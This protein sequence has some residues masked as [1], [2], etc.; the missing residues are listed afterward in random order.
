M[1][2]ALAFLMLFPSLL[3]GQPVG[4]SA[5][6]IMSKNWTAKQCRTLIRALDL[7]EEPA[8]AILWRS[9]GTA[10]RCLESIKRKAAASPKNWYIEIHLSNE[11]ARRSGRASEWDLL[12]ALT[13]VEYSQSLESPNGET[14]GAV[15]S[16]V[17]KIGEVVTDLPNTRWGLTL[18]LESNLSLK[19]AKKLRD[20][21]RQWW[22]YEIVYSPLTGH[23]W[24]FGGRISGTTYELHGYSELAATGRNNCIRN[25]DGTGIAHNGPRSPRWRYF[26]MQQVAEWGRIG[27]EN[28]CILLFWQDRWQGVDT[29]NFIP[30]RDRS[31]T[32][33][34]RDFNLVK[35]LMRAI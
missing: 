35:K 11:A 32:F 3:W 27:R 6:Q 15:S 12:P 20:L 24:A 17:R 26:T 29:E 30:H 34:R 5:Y 31:F 28:S 14:L 2:R 8:V 10:T 33:D 1:G 19:A 9:F 4:I 16:R 25:G 22:R 21:I 18:G 13:M 7:S 23:P